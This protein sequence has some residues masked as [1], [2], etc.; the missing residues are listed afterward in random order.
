MA[1]EDNAGGPDAEAGL[2]LH[3]PLVLP[4]LRGSPRQSSRCGALASGTGAGQFIVG[5]WNRMVKEPTSPSN[6]ADEL[7]TQ[8]GYSENQ[9]TPEFHLF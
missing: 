1:L 8:H 9:S 5:P 2:I 7:D 6:P 3:W 4:T